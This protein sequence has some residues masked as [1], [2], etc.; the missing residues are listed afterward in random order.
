MTADMLSRCTGLFGI[1]DL[2]VSAVV[3][4]AAEPNNVKGLAV[5]FV[6]CIRVAF[7]AATFARR[8]TNNP[9]IPDG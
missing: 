6:V 2:L 4:S 5:V 1:A 8:C 9:A 3:T 7:S